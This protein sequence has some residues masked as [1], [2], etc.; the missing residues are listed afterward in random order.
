MPKGILA[1]DTELDSPP[2]HGPNLQ[3]LG[4]PPRTKW[5]PAVKTDF[6]QVRMNLKDYGRGLLQIPSAYQEPLQPTSQ[7]SKMTD[8]PPKYVAQRFL[9]SYRDNFHTQFPIMDWHAFEAECDQLYRTTSLAS[10]GSAW[11]AVFLSV[12]A[13]G[14]LYTL[15]P[16]ATVNGKAFLSA[17]IGLTNLWQED[18]SIEKARL[19][20]LTGVFLVEMNLKPAGW[21][22][23]GSA[24]R[25]SQHIGLHH[26]TGQWP[27]NEGEMRRRLWYCIYAWDRSAHPFLLSRSLPLLLRFCPA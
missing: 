8:L 11:G 14:T 9:T 17:A 18:F 16:G 26:E 4:S 5:K 19:A 1:M 24:V 22:W 13:C 27:F 25:I 20:F 21:V 15:D 2:H 10:L 23:L 12:L 6:S 3:S 7:S